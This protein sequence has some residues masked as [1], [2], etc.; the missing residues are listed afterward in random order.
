MVGIWVVNLTYIRRIL[1]DQFGEDD[2]AVHLQQK[3]LIKFL[4]LTL[5]YLI[6]IPLVG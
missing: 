2:S 6:L 4:L 3:P 5:P 1:G